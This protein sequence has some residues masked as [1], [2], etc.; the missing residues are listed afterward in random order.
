[1]GHSKRIA[2]V[3]VTYNR[4]DMLKE[5]IECLLS[6]TVSCLMDI[7]VV[8]NASTD[9]TDEFLSQR[10]IAGDLINLNTGEN[11]GGAGGFQFG[12]RY[13][14]EQGYELVWMMDDDCMPKPNALEELLVWDDV[15]D[16][17]YGFL[18]SKAVWLDGSPCKMNVQHVD[19][20]K[21]VSP[22]TS[23]VTRIEMASFVSILIR[24]EAVR[25][26]GLPIK[27]F[28]IWADDIEYTHRLSSSFPSY[29]V[30]QSVVVHKS[31]SN[32][33]SN[34]AHD[35][36]D[37]IPRYELAYR[38]E[39]YLYRGAGLSARAY[40]MLRLASH[41]G[42]TLISS[43]DH[44]SERLTAI[45]RGTTNGLRFHPAVEYCEG[46]IRVLELF[47]EPISYGGQESFVIGA[48]T[49]MDMTDLTIDCCTPYYCDNENH[50]DTIRKLGGEVYEFGLAFEPGKSRGNVEE[51]LAAFLGAKSYDV[52][53]IHSGST[54]FLSKASRVAKL[55]GTRKVIV[56]SHATVERVSFK[57]RLIREYAAFD[58]RRFPDEYCACS[59]QAGRV[60]YTDDVMNKLVIIKNGVD[61]NEFRYDSS[62][63]K[64]MRNAIGVSDDAF[65]VGHVGRFSPEKNHDFLLRVFSEVCLVAEDARL[66]L[67][68][69]GPTMDEIRELSHR[70][71]IKDKVVFTGNTSD[72]ASYLQ[73]MDVFVFPSVFEGLGIVAIEAQAAGL[74]VV[75]SNT[76]PLD[77]KI[78]ENYRCLSLDAGISIWRDA[79][80]EFRGLTRKDQSDMIVEAGFDVNGT[81]ATLRDLYFA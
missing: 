57:K 5:C 3:V 46:P 65:V 2:T 41:V 28:F 69:D 37:R 77:A 43:A 70:L 44:K 22:E 60:K 81:A 68:G 6:Q 73:A 63:R 19:F 71:G 7:I 31:P 76:V 16:G 56:H 64:K 50:R 62:A 45:A 39:M 15:L 8:D 32:N 38:N 75:A 67:V 13:A 74:P 40:Q 58:M 59:E 18:S 12:L 72:V 78:T 55:A 26:V 53:H 23:T 14:V 52:V 11:L 34:I 42:K 20:W 54:T 47:G 1:M 61:I 21:K 36:I 30:P 9:G 80:V 29:F 51:P 25:A 79:I 10:A 49:H 4:I 48:L 24:S 27:E 33:G 17:H 66:L 35:S